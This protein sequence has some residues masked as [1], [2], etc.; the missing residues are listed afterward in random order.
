MIPTF[1]ARFGF[2]MNVSASDA[3][4]SCQALLNCPQVSV[5][6]EMFNTDFE[7]GLWMGY[8]MGYGMGCGIDWSGLGGWHGRI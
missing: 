2:K 6:G 3:V 4:F 8:G 7:G 1:E 5:G